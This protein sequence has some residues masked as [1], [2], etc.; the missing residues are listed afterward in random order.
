MAP[1]RPKSPATLGPVSSLALARQQPAIAGGLPLNPPIDSE[2]KLETPGSLT[3]SVGPGQDFPTL[4]RAL[5]Y[6]AHFQ[7]IGFSPDSPVLRICLAPDFVMQEQIKVAGFNLAWIEIIPAWWLENKTPFE[8][9][10]DREALTRNVLDGPYE[11]AS[12]AAFSA[13]RG[14]SLPMIRQMF[15]M[16]DTGPANDRDGVTVVGPGSSEWHR[17]DPEA[18]VGIRNAGGSGVRA[19]QGAR[20]SI[21]ETCWDNAGG[22]A[23]S[24]LSSHLY[25]PGV[26]IHKARMRGILSANSTGRCRQADIRQCGESALHTRDA[27]F[28]DIRGSTLTENGDAGIF[29]GSSTTVV[30]GNLGHHMTRVNNN[31][32]SGCR[33]FSGTIHLSGIGG[34]AEVLGNKSGFDLE[35]TMGGN[36]IAHQVKTTNATNEPHIGYQPALEDTNAN[37]FSRPSP[38]G[39]GHINGTIFTGHLQAQ[40]ST[41]PVIMTTATRD[42]HHYVNI[43]GLQIQDVEISPEDNAS[44]EFNW[45]ISILG[46]DCFRVHVSP[47]PGPETPFKFTW[48]ATHSGLPVIKIDE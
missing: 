29:C 25:G 18:P 11:G 42:I 10:I 33:A 20:I 32:S 24:M 7:P 14:G 6:L 2:H 28:F 12:Y 44:L 13:L 4:N 23:L 36:I 17:I 26:H 31:R 39:L 43:P 15:V 27:G 22:N 46:P 35:I 48:R 3:V 9:V 19:A 40:N 5:G 30:A 16:T 34:S 1:R 45:R 21:P 8:T 37:T 47:E 41:S 38:G